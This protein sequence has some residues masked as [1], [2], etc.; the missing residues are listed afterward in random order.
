MYLAPAQSADFVKAL[1]CECEQFDA[2]AV[3]IILQR[4]PDQP[5]LGRCQHA[6]PGFFLVLFRSNDR[7]IFG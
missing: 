3:L 2:C 1:A 7:I 6:V 5:E 4:V